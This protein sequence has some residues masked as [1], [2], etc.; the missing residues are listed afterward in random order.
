MPFTMET[1][2]ARVGGRNLASQGHIVRY[3]RMTA[4]LIAIATADNNRSHGDTDGHESGATPLLYAAAALT[5]SSAVPYMRAAWPVLTRG[6]GGGGG[7]G[8]E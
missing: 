2:V 6:G 3:G 7:L 4:M 8:A 1:R 5:V